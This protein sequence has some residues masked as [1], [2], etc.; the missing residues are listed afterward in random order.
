M[1]IK[2]WKASAIALLSVVGLTLSACGGDS[3][4]KN[5]GVAINSEQIADYA[6]TARDGIKDGGEMNLAVAEVPE[7]ENPFHADASAYTTDI[8]GLYNPQLAMFTPEGEYSP[9]EDYLTKVEDKEEDNKTIVTFTFRDDAKYNDGTP[10]D[11]TA[12]DTTW[13]F[14]N[15][16]MD[17]VVPSSTDGYKLIESVT[18]GE[19]DK[20]AVVTFK[21]V[22]PWW[23]G[24]FNIILPPHVKTAEDF[25]TGFLTKVHPE[26]GAGPFKLDNIDFNTGT[27]SVVRNDKW[28]GDPAK[29]ER[30]TYRVMEEQASLNAFRAGEIDA[31]GVSNKDRLETAKKMGD[32]AEIRIG[33]AP[34]N[35]LLTLNSQAGPLKD[36]KVREAVMSGIDR[37]QL[38]EIRFNGLDYQENAP[39][40]FTLF[41]SQEG[42]EDNFGKVVTF[43]AEK[44]K[45]LL[46]EAG[47]KEGS[48]GIREKNGEKLSLKYTLLGDDA[49]IK[50]LAQAIQQMMRGIGVELTI[51]QK[52]TSDFSKIVKDR[53]FDL[54]LMAFRSGDP[55]GVAYFDQIY[56]SSSELNKSG[57]GSKE[58]DEKIV[59]LT[60]IHDPKE[61][62]AKANE[63][64]QEAFGFH[65]IMPLF[66]GPAIS[67]VKPGLVNFGPKMFGNVKVQDIGWKKD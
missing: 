61:Q 45:S 41:S 7:Q 50:A 28:W 57:T 24:L 44:A 56:S 35:S 43:D 29:L 48:D 58:F 15:G 64:E 9:N 32:Q 65:G 11:W 22:Y 59:E 27:V 62:I 8:W 13:R 1:K 39:G 16:E 33:K 37:K 47:W 18:K 60:K 40:S 26:W 19:T 46:D 23:Q 38:A 17:G 21:Q 5:S 2:P 36:D 52:P 55:F 20:Q 6:P 10:I 67:A 25:N 30:I 14:N 42:Y 3:T 31:T 66:N 4:E 54:F 34:S 63:L 53:A 49:M 12:I 51:D